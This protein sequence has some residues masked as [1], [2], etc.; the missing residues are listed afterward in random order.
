MTTVTVYDVVIA[1]RE[2]ELTACPRCGAGHGSTLQLHAEE[3][4]AEGASGGE[5][6]NVGDRREPRHAVFTT[7][8]RC[9][10]GH[11][12]A[13]GRFESPESI[14]APVTCFFCGEVRPRAD[15]EIHP[16]GFQCRD[17]ATCLE[18]REWPEGARR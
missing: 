8:V 10:C 3:G 7:A 9:S 17:L 14:D 16:A 6:G 12:L 13:A 11:L 4:R 5:S 18:G 1:P 2:V 15:V